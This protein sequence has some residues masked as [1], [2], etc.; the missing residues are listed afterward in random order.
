MTDNWY[1]DTRL[2]QKHT[3]TSANN[4]PILEQKKEDIAVIG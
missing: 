4:M 1:K 3:T 2:M